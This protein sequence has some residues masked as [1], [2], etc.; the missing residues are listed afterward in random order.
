MDLL[1]FR[2]ASTA[3]SRSGGADATD[4][5]LRKTLWSL[6]PHNPL[7]SLDSDERIQGNPRKSNPLNPGFQ[8]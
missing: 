2:M 1:R 5:R 6:M 7:I 8:S 4:K 3:C